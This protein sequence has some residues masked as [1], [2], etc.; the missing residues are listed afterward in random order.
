MRCGDHNVAADIDQINA[1]KRKFLRLAAERL[2]KE[3]R[4]EQPFEPRSSQ[5]TWVCVWMSKSYEN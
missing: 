1:M 2:G 5:L 3:A 4:G